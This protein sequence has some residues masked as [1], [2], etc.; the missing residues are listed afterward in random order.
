MSQ[1]ADPFLVP[2]TISNTVSLADNSATLALTTSG[3]SSGS[4]DMGE[5]AGPTPSLGRY[6]LIEEVA[7][8]GMG[9]IYRAT[10]SGLGREV[11]VKVLNERFAPESATARRFV[12]EAR[13]TGRLQHPGIPPV[14]DCGVLSNGR[15]FLA[16][17]LIRGSTLD[18]LLDRRPH[19]A[20]DLPGFVGIFEQIC[21]AL[22]YA[23]AHHVIH[24]DLKPGNVMV[25][26]FGEVQVMDWGLAKVIRTEDNDTR[27]EGHPVV[28]ESLSDDDLGSTLTMAGS[29]LGT[30]AFMPPEQARGG[31]ATADER[32]DVFG[33][34]AILCVILTGQPPYHGRAPVTVQQK[35]IRGDLADALALLNGCGADADLLDLCSACLAPDPTDRPPNAGEVARA[36]AAHRAAVEERAR[37]AEVDRA[38]GERGYTVETRVS[39]IV[40]DAWTFRV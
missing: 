26:A 25:G 17:K 23:H 19:P 5:P 30:P 8:G 13:I 31:A 4:D 11:A 20:A 9:V 38:A 24:R 18:A 21:Q 33:L 34:G 16:M 29:M 14:H 6:E 35:A 28:P 2:R 3:D 10:D 36:V 12:V 32:A 27:G 15:P 7:R 37:R 1:P 40:T 22:A 39:T